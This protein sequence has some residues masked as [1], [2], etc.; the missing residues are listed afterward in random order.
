[1][2]A[3]NDGE[4]FA[5]DGSERVPD[6]RPGPM[7]LEPDRYFDEPPR[8][9]GRVVSMLS[10]AAQ[11]KKE[12]RNGLL[13]F[14]A[15]MNAAPDGE[16][17]AILVLFSRFQGRTPRG[18]IEECAELAGVHRETVRR[19]ISRFDEAFPD[20]LPKVRG[21]SETGRE[22]DRVRNPDGSPRG[23]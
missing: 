10:W 15:W 8:N 11:A 5:D 18:A 20:V 13:R 1:M 21:R 2:A 22:R 14:A 9:D 19:A 17:R 12:A 7:F 23:E 16:R 3:W 6:D 4:L